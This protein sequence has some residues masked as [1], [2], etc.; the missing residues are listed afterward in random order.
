MEY[1]ARFLSVAIV[2]LTIQMEGHFF[3]YDSIFWPAHEYN[4][5]VSKLPYSNP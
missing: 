4:H 1:S 2:H 3:F 5:L